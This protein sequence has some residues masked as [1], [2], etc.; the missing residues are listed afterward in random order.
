LKRLLL[1]LIPVALLVGWLF[2][3]GARPA[4]IPFTR[5]VRETIVSTLNTNGKVEPIEWAAAHA[6]VG[7]PIAQVH[8]ERG[9]A[10]R[11][12]Q[13]LVTISLPEVR[14]DIASAQ[15]RIDAAKA[16]LETL[17][18]G[19]RASERTEIESGL[20]RA[21]SDLANAQTEYATLQRLVA[22]NAATKADLEVARQAVERAQQQIQTLERKR[23]SLV[24]QPDKSAAE[25]RLQEAQSGANAASQ[26]LASGEVHSPVSGILYR[27]D[28]KPGGY[29]NPGDLVAEVGRL[30]Q[31]R[32][33]VYV[34]EP[35]LGRV[36]KGMPVTITWDAMPGR[37]WKGF[38]ESV[39]LQVVP[40]GTRQVGEV[41][42]TIDNPDLTLIPGTNVNA[43]I[44][45]KVAENALVVPKEVIR[46]QGSHI[47][48]FTLDGDKLAWRVV[49][50]GVSS[51]TRVQ[52]TDGLKEGDPVALQVER[53][54]KAGE[55]VR[56]VF[57]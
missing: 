44:R 46:R 32:V 42:C 45:S 3:R 6:E 38:V 54:L 37:Q 31:L 4:E 23:S 11:K 22:K 49:R 20:V 30:N 2:A 35:D 7:G 25:A 10:V 53:T 36:E 9:Q 50:T 55:E 27:L 28:V 18:Q 48:V 19:G 1:L 5:V 57:P 24:S 39:P 43:E 15:A 29:L 16:E 14:A 34:D 8:V 13:L 26:R 33:R 56:A 40:L 47:G 12:G 17:N 41:I 52:V 51:V 21:K